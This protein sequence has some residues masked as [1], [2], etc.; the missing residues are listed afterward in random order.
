M[1]MTVLAVAAAL[2]FASDADAR[3]DSSSPVQAG[4]DAPVA[5]L[6]VFASD[7][8]GRNRGDLMNGSSATL[9][10][11]S[12]TGRYRLHVVSNSGGVMRG[13]DVRSGLA[14]R[15]RF[16]DASGSEQIKQMTGGEIVFEGRSPGQVDCRGGA[17]A[18]VLIDSPESD[19]LANVAGEYTDR[20]T[21]SVEPL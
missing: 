14:Y 7:G 17:N 21:L 15:V 19:I 1:I 4:A 6:R 20:L 8:R 2:A 3:R 12:T 16:R 11:A 13:N 18:S 9:C 10:V 5:Q